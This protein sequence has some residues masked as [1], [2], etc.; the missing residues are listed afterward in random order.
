[1]AQGGKSG[2]VEIPWI[3]D[4]TVYEFRL[5]PAS[6]PELLIDSVKATREIESASAALS[7]IADEVTRGN[8][9]PAAPSRFLAAVM[10]I[11]LESTEIRNLFQD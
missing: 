7:D 3:T 4:S 1:V 5:Y 9:D 2:H 11:C 6:R 8:I 10:P